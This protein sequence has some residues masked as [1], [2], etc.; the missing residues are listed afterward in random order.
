MNLGGKMNANMVH[1]V[2]N[3]TSIGV[4]FTILQ[5]SSM[6]PG[7]YVNGETT[8]FTTGAG[9]ASLSTSRANRQHCVIAPVEQMLK[10]GFQM[11]PRISLRGSVCPHRS[12]GRDVKDVT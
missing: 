4:A 6:F 12:M 5:A 9:D 11:R 7:W 10:F 2:L 8:V 3:S 1:I